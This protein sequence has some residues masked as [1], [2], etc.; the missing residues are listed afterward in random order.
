MVLL[1]DLVGLTSG[2]LDLLTYRNAAVAI[3]SIGAAEV[4]MS[5]NRIER[6]REGETRPER[7][8]E[9]ERE[10]EGERRNAQKRGRKRN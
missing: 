2:S 6:A 4:A 10:R 3:P 9:R 7:E 5:K 8:Q 1:S